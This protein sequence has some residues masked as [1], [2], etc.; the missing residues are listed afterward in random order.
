MDI[1]DEN[2]LWSF[3]ICIIYLYNLEITQMRLPHIIV[4]LVIKNK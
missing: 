3:K 1:H 2:A 4:F